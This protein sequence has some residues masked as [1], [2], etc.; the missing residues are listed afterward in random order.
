MQ[1][2]HSNEFSQ[3]WSGLAA[4]YVEK[5]SFSNIWSVDITVLL[6]VAAWDH[7]WSAITETFIILKQRNECRVV[8]SCGILPRTCC[9]TVKPDKPQLMCRKTVHNITGH[10]LTQNLAE[11]LL[12]SYY[13]HTYTVTHAR[14]V[15]SAESENSITHITNT[16]QRQCFKQTSLICYSKQT[17]DNKDIHVYI[18]FQIT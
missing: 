10:K 17:G 4:C 12:W 9:V 14:H 1:K 8:W 11:I 15:L 7:K 6:C 16:I 5:Y 3:G 2:N 18:P 13:T